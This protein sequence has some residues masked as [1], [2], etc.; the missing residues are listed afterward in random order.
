MKLNFSCF[1]LLFLVIPG[2]CLFAQHGKIDSLKIILNSTA[3]DSV[4]VLAYDQ[5]YTLTD[6]IQY[7]QNELVLA[8][9]IKQPSGIAVSL[10]HIGRSNY[11]SGKEDVSLA[12]LIRAVKMA[13]EIGDKKTLIAGYR[14]VGFIYRPHEPFKAKEYYE[15]SLKLCRETGDDYSASYALSALGNVYEGIYDTTGLNNRKALDYYEQ[16]L[17]IRERL[18]SPVEIAASYN[19]TS[20]MYDVL[21]YS[22]KAHRLRIKGLE[23]AQKNNDPE[24]IVYLCNV[25]GN[26][27]SNRLHDYQNGLKYELMAYEAGKNIRNNY[28]LLF[29]V[30]K[31]V[32]ICYSK[33]GD[34]KNSNAFFMMSASFNDSVR[35]KAKKYDYN[36]SDIKQSLEKEVEKQKLLVKDAQISKANAETQSETT[37]RNSFLAGSCL[38]LAFGIYIFFAY[39]QKQKSNNELDKRNKE[40][41]VAYESLAISEGNF[42]QITETINDVFYL[43]NIRDKKYEYINKNCSTLFGLEPDYFYSGKSTKVFVHKDDLALVVDANKKIDSGI[44]YDIE[45][46]IWINGKIKWVAEKSSPIFDDAGTLIRN[47]GICRDITRRKVAEE[48]LRKKNKDITDSIEYGSKIQNAVLVPKEVIAKKLK[49]F[50]ILFRPKDIV[51]GD[52]YF[53]SET[54]KGIVIAA[55]DCTG[56]GVSA[57]FMSMIGNAFLHEIVT[58]KG[59]TNP[60]EIL[61]QLRK[62]IIESLNQNVGISEANDGIDIALLYFDNENNCVEYAG[63]FNSLYFIRNNELQEYKA[64]L[65]PVGISFSEKQ[66]VFRSTKI[67]LQK[68]DTFYI[69]SDGYADQ[70]GGPKERK[71]MKKPMQEL[72]L[73]IQQE[74]ME[75]QEKIM[76]E[77]FLEWKGELDQLDDVLVIGIRV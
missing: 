64:D 14:Y 31:A 66:K 26:D 52:F 21:G 28:E 70:F 73:S 51:S 60:A 9:K 49:D 34:D 4:K 74:K 12:Y 75:T 76:L 32:A 10:L 57:G 68:G 69:F 35:A 56:H 11:F 3:T 5:L 71:F 63:A 7:A 29:D 6:S 55:C 45:Y 23:I 2:S 50:F 53:Y 47:S 30:S 33:L 59:I 48:I 58:A 19:E 40:I 15:K 20:R 42:K 24:N 46:R 8:E 41:E 43:Y 18:G 36:V 27:F 39:R 62:M 72:L 77:K 37:L 65:F 1:L 13:E 17:Q 16:S 44:F 22:E 61:S 54:T 38:L 25:L 67:E